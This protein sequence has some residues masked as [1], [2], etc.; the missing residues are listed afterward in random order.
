[1]KPLPPRLPDDIL[2]SKAARFAPVA[3]QLRMGN[4]ASAFAKAAE[5]LLDNYEAMSKAM[6]PYAVLK[7]AIELHKHALFCEVAQDKAQTQH[8]TAAY[9]AYQKYLAGETDVPVAVG[10]PTIG[11]AEVADV[12]A[13]T[14]EEEEP[15]DEIQ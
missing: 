6:Q 5:T 12:D 15:S 14:E 9:A 2:P 7:L 8:Q 1:M 10:L 13:D 11:A 3:E 4:P